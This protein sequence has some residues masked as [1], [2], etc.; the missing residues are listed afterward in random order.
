MARQAAPGRDSHHRS[1]KRTPVQRSYARLP[2]GAEHRLRLRS[3]HPLD[4]K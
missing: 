2:L 3:T 4:G 1:L